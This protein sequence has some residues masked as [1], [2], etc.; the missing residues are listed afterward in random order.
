MFLLVVSLCAVGQA[1]PREDPD[2][3]KHLI[4]RHV[5]YS[6]PG[7]SD[8]K[9]RQDIIYKREGDEELKMDVYTPVEAPANG[10]LH[11]VV[12]IHGGFLPPNLLTQPKDTGIYMSYGRLAAA[13]GFAAITFNHRFYRNWNSLRDST[14]GPGAS[15]RICANPFS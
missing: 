8:V 15:A 4:S 3:Y 12:F 11:A 13:A 2:W 7:M 1:L 14:S 5:V 10:K 9:V 6:L